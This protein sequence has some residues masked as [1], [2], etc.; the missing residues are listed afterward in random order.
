[1]LL[2][3]SELETHISTTTLRLGDR[4]RTGNVIIN[5]NLNLTGKAQNLAI[6]SN[7]NVS[8][9]ST[10]VITVANLGIDAGGT[11]SFPGTGG[12]PSVIALN[13]GGVTFNQS[14]NYNVAV[15]D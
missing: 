3:A 11:I 15:V 2:T 7:A 13:A 5:S 12:T 9:G 8:A 4:D 10:V 1:M 6:R 14:A